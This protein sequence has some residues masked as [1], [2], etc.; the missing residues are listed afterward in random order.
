MKKRQKLYG[1]DVR[2]GE[3]I[4]AYPIAEANILKPLQQWKFGL[5]S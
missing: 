5:T 3:T 1:I 2:D 4:K